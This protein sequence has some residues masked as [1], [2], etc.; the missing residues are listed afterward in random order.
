MKIYKIAIIKGDG[1]GPEIIEQSELVLKNVSQKHSF[2]LLFDYAPMG[3]E[4]ID[5]YGV[6]LPDDT[7][8][9]CKHSDA[10]LLGAVGGSKWDS[11]SGNLRPEAGLLGIRKGLELYSNLRPATV[12]EGMEE[13]SPLKNEIVK[14]LDLLIVRELTGGIYFGKSGQT[15]DCAYDTECYS[16]SEIERIAH[17]AFQSAQ[18]RRKKLCSVDKSNVLESSRLWRRVVCSVSSDYPDV[19]LSHMYVDN[20]AMQLVRNP[21]QF[22]V[23][24]TNNMFGDIL[25]DEASQISGSI[26]LLP[27]ASLGSKGI[28]LYEP[29]HGSAPDIAGLNIANPV[30]AILSCAMMCR[31]SLNQADAADDIER[32]VK[33]VLKTHRTPDIHTKN[34]IKISCTEMGKLIA[35]KIKF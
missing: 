1:I 9:L 34:T 33:K 30:G 29:I 10:V 6:P 23:I 14:G 21:S 4:A 18:N 3:G 26:G 15:D 27:S 17:S 19:E 20:C 11:L 8:T 13:A 7:L 31:Y 12:F 28:G 5:L 2:E 22:D 24:V 16:I 35:E 25:S 32:S